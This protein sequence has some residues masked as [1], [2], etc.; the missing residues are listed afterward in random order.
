MENIE[1]GVTL[2]RVFK[3]AFSNWK[4]LI[5]VTVCTVAVAAIGIQFG[6]NT[7][8]G[9]Y[10]STFSYSSVDLSK[11]QYADGSDFFYKNLIS[12][13][14][15]TAVKE[16]SSKFAS[17]DVDKILETNSISI[18]SD[19][20]EST[21]TIEL[22]YRHLKNQGLAKEFVNAITSSALTKDKDIVENG[23][24]DTSLLFFD[25]ASTFEEQVKY[26]NRQG[27]F[28]ASSYDNIINDKGNQ[29]DNKKTKEISVA[30]KEKATANKE[31]VNII[32]TEDFVDSMNIIIN[33]NGYVK[34]YEALEVKNYPV[35][36]EQ[37]VKEKELNSARVAELR[38]EINLITSPAIVNSFGQ[39]VQTLLF[40]NA[41][42]DHEVAA[43]DLKL[44]NKGIIPA[45]YE[46]FVN[47][48][49]NYRERLSDAVTDYKQVLK[50]AYINDAEVS[51]TNTS[52]IVLQGNIPLYFNLPIS[53]VL[54][55]VVGGVVNLIVDRKKLYE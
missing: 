14:N 19:S 10:S 53:L 8:R 34:D 15:L 45:G 12:Y 6:L 21:Y 50:E 41:E 44:A 13:K 3:V 39:E 40:R 30:I 32:I 17:I 51:Y 20:E 22:S 52:I 36:R 9:Y 35:T 37:L 7:L 29:N 33:S 11:E 5:P 54:G 26:L 23:V 16:S 28:L 43:I 4:L 48:L 42:I 55:L 49:T 38:N 47:T 24:F 46:D 25:E 2:E 31:K 1:K 18:S 27:E